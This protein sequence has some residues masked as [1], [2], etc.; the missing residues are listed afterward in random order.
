MYLKH[1]TST[2]Q[3]PCLS[4][5]LS[6]SSPLLSFTLLSFPFLFSHYYDFSPSSFLHSP[7]IFSSLLPFPAIFFPLSFFPSLPFLSYSS[8]YGLC[9][10][11]NPS[12]ST[13]KTEHLYSSALKLSIM[14]RNWTHRQEKSTYSTY[15]DDSTQRNIAVD[16]CWV[17]K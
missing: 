6:Y 2:S 1:T 3:L 4:A 17:S 12:P 13:L 11:W 7:L 8:G 16:Y 15:H 14:I 5:I 10:R 9:T